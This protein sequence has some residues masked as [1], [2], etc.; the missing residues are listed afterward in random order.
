MMSQAFYTGI[1]GMQASM[2]A[3]NVISDNLANTSTIGF[4]SYSSEFSS[5][6]EQKINTSSVSSS[7]SSSIGVGSKMSSTIMDENK[8]VFQLSD[9]STD[10]AILGDGWFGIQGE[11]ELLYTRDGSFTF[12]AN[13]ALVTHDGYYALGTMGSNISDSTLT[14]QLSS[15]DLGDIDTQEKLI[16]P[17]NLIIAVQPTTTATFSGN[18]GSEDVVRVISAEV[19]DSQDNRND[20]R[21]QF[22]KSAVQPAEGSSWDIV[23][24]VE[25]RE[26]LTIY[27]TQNG[28][29]NFNGD[30]SLLSNTL[31]SINNN[32]STVSIDLGSGFTGVTSSNST[33][34]ASSQTD[35]LSSGELLGYDI[36]KNGEVIATFS[37][38]LQSAVGRVA[39]YHFQNDRGLERVNGSRFQESANSGKAIFF[40]DENGNNII[41]TDITNF[42]L[43]GSNVR[44]EVALT[45][46]IIMQRAFDAN[47]KSITTSDQMLQKALNMDA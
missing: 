2:S 37:N 11:E 42:K 14:S 21:L 24:T 39:V 19:I 47:S 3:I 13:R 6:F 22:T 40:Q 26:G 35:G 15:V 10:L 8:G 30:G 9:L 5:M 45:E 31:S 43:E 4:R 41:G 32:G 1:S 7:V 46:I 38:G 16:F 27:D 17:D 18:L 25:S 36:N 28:V 34:S 12:D 23:A 33:F 44:M 29:V 20:L